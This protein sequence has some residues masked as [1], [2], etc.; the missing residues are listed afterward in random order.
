MVKRSDFQQDKVFR[1]DDSVFIETVVEVSSRAELRGGVLASE[2][3]E[4][5]CREEGRLMVLATL[6][7]DLARDLRELEVICRRSCD[8]FDAMDIT[9]RFH[10]V[11][12]M[13]DGGEF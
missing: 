13:L 5:E 12:Y 6:W 1:E 7:G 2:H 11:F 3:A 4:L 9:N 10:R 8:R